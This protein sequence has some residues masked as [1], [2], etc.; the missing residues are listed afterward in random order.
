MTARRSDETP[1]HIAIVDYL[2]L[3]LPGAL[4]IHIPNGGKRGAREAAEF[5]RMGVVAG[6]PDIAIL[7]GCGGVLFIEVKAPKG[8]LSPEQEAFAQFCAGAHFPFGVCRSVDDARAFLSAN[9][10]LTREAA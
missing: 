2:R 10:I 8:K 3:V 9:G 1:I 4:V 5:Q 7:L 6:V